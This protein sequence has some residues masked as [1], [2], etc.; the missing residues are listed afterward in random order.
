MI[1][2]IPFQPRHLSLFIHCDYSSRVRVPVFVIKYSFTA[3]SFPLSLPYPDCL[4]PPK[5]DSAAEELPAGVRG[6]LSGATQY[7][8]VFRPIIPASSF[9]KSLHKRS[10][11]LVKQ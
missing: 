8:P 4:I 5:G 3:T 9:S 2:P 6:A 7:K 1:F 11:F 10:T